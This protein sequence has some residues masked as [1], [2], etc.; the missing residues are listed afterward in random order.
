MQKKEPIYLCNETQ[1]ICELLK[2]RNNVFAY[3]LNGND[4]YH[5]PSHFTSQVY[6]NVKDK[7]LI[8]VSIKKIEDKF[9]IIRK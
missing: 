2:N 3:H 5:T 6:N 9:Y 8:P 1:I 7:K 4:K